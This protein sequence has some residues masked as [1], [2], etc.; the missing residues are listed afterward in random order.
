MT[1][2]HTAP[3]FGL[4][5]AKGSTANYLSGN[6]NFVAL[7]AMFLALLHYF[8]LHM[9]LLTILKLLESKQSSCGVHVVNNK[10]EI[11]TFLGDL[12]YFWFKKYLLL[13]LKEFMLI[14]G[15]ILNTICKF[16]Y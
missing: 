13:I 2:A 1:Q 16:V 12:N 8:F 10:N 14:L 11:A 7:R 6:R 3:F 9:L 4:L 5:P 15:L